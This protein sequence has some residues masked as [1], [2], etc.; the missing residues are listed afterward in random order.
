M[1]CEGEIVEICIGSCE[2]PIEYIEP[3]VWVYMGCYIRNI[4]EE[5]EYFK[6]RC[7]E[8][9]K[10]LEEVPKE[11]NEW[12]CVSPNAK[13]VGVFRP[14][15]MPPHN[16]DLTFKLICK[17]ESGEIEVDEKHHIIKLLLPPG[18]K[19]KITAHNINKLPCPNCGEAK[20]GQE[21]DVIMSMKNIGDEEGE[22]RFYIY[23]QDGN[24]LSKE[25][26][27]TYKNI[28]AGKTWGVSKTLTTN[29]NFD[30]INKTLN[31]KVVLRRQT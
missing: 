4:G 5:P 15:K 31:G 11:K 10:F 16:W 7:Y 6:I 2:T 1:G 27:F 12:I 20:E 29:L 17:T 25:P 8:G 21:I 18:P 24:E 3:N 23:D 28:K 9:D 22:F 30:M 19:G 14:G 26:D 13:K